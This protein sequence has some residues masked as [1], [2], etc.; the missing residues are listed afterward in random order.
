LEV[1]RVP[2]EE[3]LRCLTQIPEVAQIDVV[4]EH[5]GDRLRGWAPDTI[6][7]SRAQQLDRRSASKHEALDPTERASL[8]GA[9]DRIRDV[10]VDGGIGVVSVHLGDERDTEAPRYHRSHEPG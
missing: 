5:A 2:D 4:R 8:E 3:D 10:G 6:E 9:H 7:L 1:K